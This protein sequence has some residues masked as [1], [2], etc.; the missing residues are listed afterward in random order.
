MTPSFPVRKHLFLAGAL[1][2]ILL[3]TSWPLLAQQTPEAP[4]PWAQG[5]PAQPGAAMNLAPV[6]PPPIPAAADQLPTSK[7]TVP[8]DF[9]IEVYASGVDNARS[10]RIGDKGTVF[11][12]SRLKDKVHAIVDTGGKREVKVIAFDLYRPNGLVFHNGTLYVAELSRISKRGS[13]T[14]STIRR[15]RW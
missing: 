15:S 4:P 6:A 1:G 3:T 11:V 14:T 2:A 7:L 13:R 5:R 9:N 8:K 12:G 10:L